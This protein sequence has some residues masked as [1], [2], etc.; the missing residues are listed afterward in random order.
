GL[1]ALRQNDIIDS[2]TY[3]DALLL[4]RSG[5]SRWIPIEAEEI[6]FHLRESKVIDSVLVETGD[7][8]ALRRHLAACLSEPDY[9]QRPPLPRDCPNQ[10]GELGFVHGV[11]NAVAR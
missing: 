8:C 7:L 3:F 11:I 1:R 6:L 5:N 4:L 9:L 10:T 2:E